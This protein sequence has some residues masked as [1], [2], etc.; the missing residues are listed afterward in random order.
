MKDAST[1]RTRPSERGSQSRRVFAYCH[2][3][4][5]LGH[6]NR[7]LAICERIGELDASASFLLATGTPYVPLFRP[8]PGIDY[9]KLPALK[10]VDNQTYNGKYLSLPSEQLLRCREA[11][12]LNTVKHLDPDLVLIDKAP[13][14]VCGELVP[15]LRW[16][17][18]NRPRTRVVFG[19]RD[20]E[21]EREA[22][23]AQ[24]GRADV[25]RMLEVYFDE[26]WVYGTR[27]VFD[28]VE[29][30]QLSPAIQRKLHFMGYIARDRCQHSN[31]AAAQPESVLVTVGGGTDGESLLD[32]YLREA[33]P[34]LSSMGLRS[35]LVGGPDLPQ[36][37][38]KRLEAVASAIAG[39]EW[40]EFDACMSCRIRDARLVVSMGGYNTL[41]QIARYCK[42]AL[43]VPRTKPR[44]EQSIRAR[45]WSDRGAV[46]VLDP[47]DLTATSLSD[48][49]AGML[50]GASATTPDLDLNGLDR[51]SERF[52]ML[53]EPED[54]HAAAV[55]L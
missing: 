32:H 35:T 30:Y 29:Q 2:D 10:K 37:V 39:V 36:D 19:M 4:V 48:T 7:T 5:G 55:R 42:P 1:D 12:L 25:P 53:W 21:D 13:L 15:T 52:K 18:E 50:S 20:I 28:V 14:G 51:V 43:I 31:G 3:S 9:I 27:S 26:I 6:L 22:T 8:A 40:I 46:E 47:A 16:L 23:I 38:A 41:C 45:L 33:A 11:V 24:W 44:A 34:R 49:V 17:K 54:R